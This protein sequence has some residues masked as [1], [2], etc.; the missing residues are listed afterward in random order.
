MQKHSDLVILDISHNNLSSLPDHLITGK[1]DLLKLDLSGNQL[2]VLADNI[3]ES[4]KYLLSLNVSHN[5]LSRLPAGS[6]SPRLVYVDFSHNQASSPIAA[7]MF[8]GLIKVNEIH[9]GHNKLTSLPLQIFGS[10]RELKYLDLSHNDIS[11]VEELMFANAVSL[12]EIDLSY[13]Q[14]TDIGRVFKDLEHLKVLNL[15]RNKLTSIIPYQFP[16]KIHHIDLSNNLISSIQDRSFSYL[17]NIRTVDLSANKLSRINVKGVETSYRLITRPEFVIRFNPLVC[18]CHLGWLKDWLM[19][20]SKTMETL[21]SFTSPTFLSCE[22]PFHGNTIKVAQAERS[23][24]L[25]KY[26]RFCSEGCTCCSFDC[27]CHY[28]C[29]QGCQCYRGDSVLRVQRVECQAAGLTQVPS[30]PDG[31]TELRLDG[32]NITEF[33]KFTFVAMKDAFDVFL[34][35]SHLQRIHDCDFWGMKRVRRLYLNDNLLRTLEVGAFTGLYKLEELHLHGNKL[36]GI[37]SGSLLSSPTLIS[38]TLHS[39]SLVT[40]PVD[41]LYELVSR[42]NASSA[43]TNRSCSR[44]RREASH[45]GLSLTLRDNPWSCEPSFA[46]SF[47]SYLQVNSDSIEDLQLIQCIPEPQVV[48]FVPGDYVGRQVDTSRTARFNGSSRV[49]RTRGR[50]ILDLQ[51]DVCNNGL[52]R[53]N[54]SLANVTGARIDSGSSDNQ[55]YM[56]I[57]MCVLVALVLALLLA[58]FLN[59]HILQVGLYS[60]LS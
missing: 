57:A 1:E 40:L 11:F 31:A 47:L 18:D 54:N 19:G 13:N 38:L 49:H 52:G 42:S 55:K 14:L 44:S 26:D 50:K 37:E 23:S 36:S 9:L 6:L 32:N 8:N 59:R 58:V 30:L 22:S 10:C 39:N 7:D 27:H 28:I 43:F 45:G 21:P 3:F 51:L 5:R 46:C 2:N 16:P 48:A 29:P 12:E 33:N 25:C 35:H 15:A 34:N 56:L 53:D 20:T 24:F 17:L 60:F 41:D 4:S